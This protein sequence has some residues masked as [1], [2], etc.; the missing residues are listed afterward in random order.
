MRKLAS[1]MNPVILVSFA[2]W[3]LASIVN[4]LILVFAVSMGAQTEE[5]CINN[6][7]IDASIMNPLILVS[8]AVPMGA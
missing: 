2:V 3:K 1:M 7:P 5:A 4:P 8:F 6:E